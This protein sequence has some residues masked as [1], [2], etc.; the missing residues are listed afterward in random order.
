V[1]LCF[2]QYAQYISVHLFYIVYTVHRCVFVLYRSFSARSAQRSPHLREIGNS[3][4]RENLVMTSAYE[5]ASERTPSVQT[6]GVEEGRLVVR[7]KGDLGILSFLGGICQKKKTHLY[8][9]CRQT[10]RDFDLTFKVEF[11]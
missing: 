6:L 9:L 3:S 2:I 8:L 1:C 11:V 4:S 10:F 5:R 7:L